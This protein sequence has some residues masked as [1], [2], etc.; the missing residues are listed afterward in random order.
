MAINDTGY[1]QDVI[2]SQLLNQKSIRDNPKDLKI[3]ENNRNDIH[4]R[5]I[6]PNIDKVVLLDDTLE[7]IR[8]KHR[9][10]YLRTT[11]ISNVIGN[12]NEQVAT[13]R[14][15]RSNE[16]G[17]VCYTSQLELKNMKEA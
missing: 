10:E 4:E 2:K 6:D 12:V 14:K 13:K 15:S 1:D 17:L 16:M 11:P 9:P 7:E 3:I 5:D 8:D